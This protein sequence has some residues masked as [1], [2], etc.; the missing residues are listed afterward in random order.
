MELKGKKLS[1]KELK[2]ISKQVIFQ[3]SI[4]EGI[5][6]TSVE[7]L[8]FV[9]YYNSDLFKKRL[10]LHK[11]FQKINCFIEPLNL[12]GTNYN[13]H[14]IIYLDNFSKLMYLG[15][16][17]QLTD[18]L[19]TTYHELGHSHQKQKTEKYSFFERFTNLYLIP[20]I[21]NHNN[22]HYQKH[23][24]DYLTE[25]DA[26]LFGINCTETFLKNYPALYQHEKKYLDKKKQQYEYNYQNFDFHNFWEEFY[27][28]YQ[29]HPKLY[30]YENFVS[31]TFFEENKSTYKK[32]KDIKE[33]EGFDWIDKKL[34]FSII[35]SP[36][37]LKQLDSK[38][39]EIDELETMI[40]ALEYI[41]KEQETIK[42]L[43]QKL[44]EKKTYP[45]FT[46]QEENEKIS[47]KINDFQA[48][49]ITL[50]LQLYQKLETNSNHIHK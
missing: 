36:S 50:K 35:T 31:I 19:Q 1:R 47:M 32:I 37:F 49:I 34:F 3:K 33:S 43:N 16:K 46:L 45:N 28:I 4:E 13:N 6:I 15:N 42:E 40:E 23:H 30:Q 29:Q 5:D 38:S 24:D 12:G 8:T 2:K 9:E 10:K 18:L 41:K 22:P 7:S 21:R 14:I 44:Q 25:K 17:H 26:D 20:F 27:K 11:I 39:L 48:K